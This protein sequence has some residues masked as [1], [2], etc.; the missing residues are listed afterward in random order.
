MTVI[1]AKVVQN[2]ELR[3]GPDAI[4]PSFAANVVPVDEKRERR[5][6]LELRVL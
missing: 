6:P 1:L 2:F 5:M 3:R 4:S